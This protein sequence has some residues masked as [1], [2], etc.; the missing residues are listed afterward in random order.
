MPFGQFLGN[1]VIG[2]DRSRELAG[3][4]KEGRCYYAPALFGGRLVM[5]VVVVVMLRSAARADK[6]NA[7]ATA[8]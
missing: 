1:S 4:T 5:V 2:F 7:A 8:G 6:K 3:G